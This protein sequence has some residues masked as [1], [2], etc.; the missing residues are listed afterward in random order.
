MEYQNF[1]PNA[2]KSKLNFLPRLLPLPFLPFPFT[3]SPRDPLLWLLL[4]GLKQQHM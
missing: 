3:S 1:F 2:L 4:F